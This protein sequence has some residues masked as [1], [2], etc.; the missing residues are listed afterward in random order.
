M[1]FIVIP[2]LIRADRVSFKTSI[3]LF[4][5]FGSIGSGFM[6][7]EIS[8]VQ[9][10]SV[11]LGHPTYG[12]TVVL[13]SLLLA[14]GLGSLLTQRISN[15]GFI[16][17]ILLLVLLLLLCVYG[18]YSP[19]FI[20]SRIGHSNWERVLLSVTG[21]GGIGFLLGTAFPLGMKVALARASSLTPWLWGVHGTT[22]VLASVFA[23]IIALSG[24]L[25]VAFWC[26]VG[27]YLV[28]LGAFI[29]ACLREG[30]SIVPMPEKSEPV[31]IEVEAEPV[32]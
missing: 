10:L 9:R 5:F 7:V 23:M 2:L 22:T 21:L 25:S 26:G 27:C 31:T 24:G 3:P 1:G 32:E 13:F 18:F 8:Q 19:G 14:S 16:G 30:Y 6:L 11:F 4:L 20:S 15:P 28:A 29:W 12:L 17:V